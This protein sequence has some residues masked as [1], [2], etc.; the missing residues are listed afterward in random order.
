MASLPKYST[1]FNLQKT[2]NFWKFEQNWRCQNESILGFFWGH[3]LGIPRLAR[4]F[5]T[6]YVKKIF[7]WNKNK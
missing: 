7:D 5:Y 2:L 4:V 6:I 1:F 3:F